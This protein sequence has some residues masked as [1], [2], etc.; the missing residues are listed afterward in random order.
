MNPA[1][2]VSDGGRFALNSGI[3]TFIDQPVGDDRCGP[4]LMLQHGPRCYFPRFNGL[5]LDRNRLPQFGLMALQH[6]EAP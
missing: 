1:L 2:L 4:P 3:C 5:G 6:G